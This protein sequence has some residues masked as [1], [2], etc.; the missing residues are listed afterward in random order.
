MCKVDGVIHEK[1]KF[2]LHTVVNQL[3]LPLRAIVTRGNRYDLPFL[4]K[5]IEDL[6]DYVLAYAGSKNSKIR[7]N[8]VRF[9]GAEPVIAPN[10]RRGKRKKV[11]HVTLLSAKLAM[12]LSSLTVM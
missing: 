9:I 12:L 10:P 3:G 7:R 1:G 11:R 6:E 4:P 2:R 8:A 5:I